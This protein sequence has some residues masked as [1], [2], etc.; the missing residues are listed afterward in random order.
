[1]VKLPS[2]HEQLFRR[3]DIAVQ[4]IDILRGIGKMVIYGRLT[5][6]VISFLRQARWAMPAPWPRISPN[7]LQHSGLFF[8]RWITHFARQYCGF[9]SGTPASDF[10]KKIEGGTKCIFPH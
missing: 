10:S 3:V 4:S 8:T 2:V 7:R 5:M 6:C 9:L 1:L